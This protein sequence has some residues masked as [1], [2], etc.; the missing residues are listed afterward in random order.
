MR[1]LLVSKF[2]HHVGGVET[3]LRWLAA[4]LQADGHDVA[5]VGMRPDDGERLMDFASAETFQTPAR[6]F[7]DG[8]LAHRAVSAAASVYSRATAATMREALRSFRPDV[9]HY[10]GTCYQLTSS[11]VRA[12]ADAGVRRVA[13]AHEYKLVCANQRLWSDRDSAMCTRC[14]GATRRQ[15]LVNPVQQSCIKGS[16][17]ASL[18]GGVEA[19]VSDVVTRRARDLTIHA[20]S[21]FMA[22]TLVQD[23][24]AESQI[25]VLDLPWPETS[26]AV[27]AGEHGE[28]F[29]YMGRLAVEKDVKTLLEGWRRAE[30]RTGAS[31]LVIAGRGAC[32]EQLRRQVAEDHI[33]RVRFVGHVD[34]AEM[35]RL[36]GRAKATVHPAAWFENS[37][38]AVR[39]SLMAGVPAMVAA[40]GGMPE[41]VRPGATGRL[42]D[43]T[44]DGWAEAFAGHGTD[45]LQAGEPVLRSVRAYRTSERQ[46]LDG[47][48]DLYAA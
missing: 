22:D 40:V 3:Y 23:G 19:V 48:L 44:A 42:V 5:L 41:L 6:H 4:S 21:R 7:V 18:I 26:A 10:H 1:V 27:R 45:G 33:D 14:V 34:S 17:G 46:H 32:E 8:S 47:L 30:D 29:L 9:V 25:R 38:L 16:R 11:V 28:H 2:L 31:H 15:R 20:P 12:A 24:W 39:E 43:H 37:P 36:L 35:G 13:T